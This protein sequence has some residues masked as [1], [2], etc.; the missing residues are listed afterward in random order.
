MMMKT[1]MRITSLL[2]ALAVASALPPPTEQPQFPVMG[3]ICKPNICDKGFGECKG[4][5]MNL[6]AYPVNI[7]SWDNETKSYTQVGQVPPFP[8]S[9][10]H[11][12]C[13]LCS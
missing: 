4:S 13:L 5:S 3:P 9:N 6:Q 7:S 1:T 10:I 8:A 2:W 11:A 12:S